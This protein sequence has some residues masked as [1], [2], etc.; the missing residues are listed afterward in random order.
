MDLSGSSGLSSSFEGVRKLRVCSWAP[1]GLDYNGSDKKIRSVIYNEPTYALFPQASSSELNLPNGLHQL[2]SR[3]VLM[4]GE[5]SLGSHNFSN[6]LQRISS[7]EAEARAIGGS[8]RSIE[9]PVIT[10]SMK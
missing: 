1:I 6:Q 9:L 3:L 8:V 7:V 4:A 5:S 2:Q 10:E